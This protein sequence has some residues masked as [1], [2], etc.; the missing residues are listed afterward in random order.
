MAKKA[1]IKNI[2]S[3]GGRAMA[4]VSDQAAAA[5]V[6][7]AVSIFIGRHIGVDA[8]GIYAITNV[9]V[10]LFRAFQSCLVLEP[11]SVF[12]PRI[13]E[14]YRAYFGFLVGLELV[15]V[16]AASVLLA[17]GA[18]VAHAIGYIE[19]DLF[20]AMLA[21]CVYLNLVCFQYFLRRQFYV[22]HRQYLATIQSFSFLVLVV[23][24]LAALW[25]VDNLTV[26]DIYMLLA[27]CSIVV[28]VIQGGRFWSQ[29]GRPSRDQVQAHSRE[30]WSY[31]KWLL[32]AVPFSILTYQGFFAIVGFAISHEAAGL[33][34]AA[35]VFIG[36]FAQIVIGMQLML[37]PMASRTVDKMSLAEQKRFAMR[38]GLLF[39]G[40]SLVYSAAVYFLREPAILL[41]FG[42]HMRDAIPVL[43][44]LALLPLFRGLPTA[45]G[46]ILSARKQANLRFISQASSTI[47]ALIIAIPMIYYGGVIGAAAGMVISQAVFAATNWACVLWLWRRDKQ[48]AVQ[49]VAPAT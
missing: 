3:M 27:A 47:I 7:F 42:E 6:S 24:G 5:G 32:M 10:L 26:V 1:R 45:A 46:V 29:M 28:C 25:R 35:E 40:G 4:S 20:V 48:L 16:F 36:P 9:F 12:G 2:V 49:A 13:T 34:K 14:N 44:I 15:C 23:A 30:H 33:L 39:L 17:L 31:G 11:M 22:D 21:S 37:V 41:L 43:A 19:A 38:I 8:L 18:T